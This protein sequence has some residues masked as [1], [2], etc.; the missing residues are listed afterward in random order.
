M[1]SCPWNELDGDKDGRVRSPTRFDDR[2]VPS[3][4]DEL[5]D[6]IMLGEDGGPGG[7]EGLG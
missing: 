6:F 4:A 2:T 5:E 3:G 7:G 1:E